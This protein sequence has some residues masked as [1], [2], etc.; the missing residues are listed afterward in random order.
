[1]G[2]HEPGFGFRHIYPCLWLMERYDRTI[3]DLSHVVQSDSYTTSVARLA[4]GQADIMVSYGHIRIK[5]SLIWQDELGG[6]GEML[7]QTGVIGVTDPIYNDT[8]SVS[9]ASPIMD[10]AFRQAVGEALI[11][12]GESEEGRAILDVFSQTG[13]AWAKDSDYDSE[14]AAQ[15][16]LKSFH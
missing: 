14:R 5:N 11:E 9:K 13:Y 10:D 16:L 4:T 7:E 1:M 6:T 12:I 8:V 15:E 2:G 3:S